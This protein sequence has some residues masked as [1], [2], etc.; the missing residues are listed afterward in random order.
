MVPSRHVL[1]ILASITVTS[2][3][4]ANWQVSEICIKNSANVGVHF[5]VKDVTTGNTTPDSGEVKLKGGFEC[6]KLSQLSGIKDGHHLLTSIKA[7]GGISKDVNTYVLYK[8]ASTYAATYTCKGLNGNLYSCELDGYSSCDDVPNTAGSDWNLKTLVNLSDFGGHWKNWF[9]SVKTCDPLLFP[10]DDNDL[11]AYLKYAHSKGY[12]VRVTGATHTGSGVVDTEKNKNTLVIS[13]G[14]YHLPQDN[15]WCQNG[16][17]CLDTTKGTVLANAGRS[18]L[19]LYQYIRPLGWFCPTQTAGYFFT[20]AG[21]VLGTVHGGAY[22]KSF[23]HAYVKRMRV[24][25]WDGSV[26]IIEGDDVFHWRSSYGMLGILTAIELDV[27]KRDSFEI[28]HKMSDYQPWDEEHFWKFVAEDAEANLDLSFF[29]GSKSFNMTKQGVYGEYFLD[30]LTDNSPNGTASRGYFRTGGVLWKT[31][32]NPKVHKTEKQL[33][34]AYAR[35]EEAQGSMREDGCSKVDVVNQFLKWADLDH[36][37][38]E[39]AVAN[40]LIDFNYVGQE[41]FV[42]EAELTTNDGFWVAGAPNVNIAALFV[43]IENAF[44]AFD[45]V[46]SMARARHYGHNEDCYRFND[47]LEYRFVEVGNESALQIVAPGRY[48]VSEVLGF[49]DAAPGKDSWQRAYAEIECE[50]LTKL[51]GK[52][53]LM[54]LHSFGDDDGDGVIAPFQACRVCEYLSD[55]Q[56]QEFEKVRK[57]WDPHGLFAGGFAYDVLLKPCPAHCAKRPACSPRGKPDCGGK[58]NSVEFV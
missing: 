7:D 49:I 36:L 25:L 55:V 42:E 33:R 26:K 41:A 32:A 37:T 38:N 2:V 28:Y 10:K 6:V 14:R 53:H 19:D 58:V 5:A 43:P 52:P 47:P 34:E 15:T 1:C 17:Y 18:W 56:K 57:H 35:S 4:G 8:A 20:L 29:P 23:L 3:H 45:F 39:A 13:L 46:R 12:K 9:E 40:L 44:E 11:K 50:W 48:V 31:P 51:K 21:T 27:I 24:M 16:D 30:F 22:G 54:K